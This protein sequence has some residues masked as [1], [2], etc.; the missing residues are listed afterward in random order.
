[1][2]T[3]KI[4]NPIKL[5]IKYTL[6]KQKEKTFRLKSRFRKQVQLII[7]ANTFKITLEKML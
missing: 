3:N 2:K 7:Q 5:S 1:M 4:K 6:K